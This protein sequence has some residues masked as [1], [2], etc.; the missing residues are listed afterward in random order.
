MNYTV[1][2]LVLIDWYSA[3]GKLNGDWN[4]VGPV[5]C[6]L[7]IINRKAGHFILLS[8]ILSSTQCRA[9][10]HHS[11][12]Q[13][14]WRTCSIFDSLSCVIASVLLYQQQLD[15][16]L[17]V[18][19][20]AYLV[21]LLWSPSAASILDQA[22]TM[23]SHTFLASFC[24]QDHQFMTH[25]Y[26]DGTLSNLD[27]KPP[28]LRIKLL[29][30]YRM[31]WRSLHVMFYGF[32]GSFTQLPVWY[33]HLWSCMPTCISL[34]I[35]ISFHPKH[36]HFVSLSPPL[37]SLHLPSSFPSFLL[38][39]FPTLSFSLFLPASQCLS[40]SLSPS[41]ARFPHFSSLS[42]PSFSHPTC[43]KS[44]LSLHCYVPSLLQE[45]L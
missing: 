24:H 5:A 22:L 42:S 31:R 45:S 20:E 35:G 13:A 7:S 16:T 21:L 10:R 39:L 40:P 6:A 12:W 34:F 32:W 29:S 14:Y 11:Q 28:H 9:G 2:S 8:I 30:H 15:I 26:P 36:S 27:R 37:P 17:T 23:P 25:Q 44:S 4:S 1:V 43:S 38:S 18:Y 33:S 19:I 41:V 3:I